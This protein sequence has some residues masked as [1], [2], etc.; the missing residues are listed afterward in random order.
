[1][2][3]SAPTQRDDVPDLQRAVSPATAALVSTLCFLYLAQCFWFITTQSLTYDEPVHIAQ[4]LDAWRNHRFEKWNDHPSLARLW[5]TLP[6]LGRKNVVEVEPLGEGWIATRLEPDPESLTRYGRLMNVL[7]GLMLAL[8][9]W[10]TTRTFFSSTAA[11]LV[12]ALFVFSPSLIAHFSLVTTD[13]AAT[14]LIF[15]AATLLMSWRAR[16]SYGRTCFMA[17]ILGLLLLAKFSTPVMFVIA[18]FWMLVL[19][20]AGARINPLLWNWRKTAVAIV[21]SMFV[22][23]A[24][25][26][27][28]VSRL[29]IHNHQLT[30]TFP[31]R[32]TVVFNNVRTNLELNILVPAGEYLDGFR[33]VV[34]RNRQGQ[35]S[36][37]MGQVSQTGGFRLYYPMAVLLKWPLIV[38]IVGGVGLG[39]CAYRRVRTSFDFWIMMSFPAVY[40]LVALVARFDIGERHILPV[41]AFFLLMAGA[42][43]QF[44]S[45]HRLATVGA[46]VI[47]GLLVADVSRYAPDYLS[48]FN[49]YVRPAQSYRLLTD[50]NLDW[51]Q[52]LIALRKY[53]RSHPG[54]PVSLAYFGSVDPRS[55]GLHV[56]VL[57]EAER[58][59]GTVIVSA[60]ALSGQYLKD[61][62]SFHWVQEYSPQ[63]LLNHS[64]FV[65]K[66]P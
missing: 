47:A 19:G 51:G 60:T 23:W 30:A 5:C 59:R 11:N 4:G 29:T 20:P 17:I 6:L 28:H 48:Y 57:G 41:Y 27:F 34:R 62:Q 36:Y 50:S 37:F 53:V 56:H 43:W 44:L 61:P 21:I 14:L 24:G 7:L 10:R 49:I 1:V 18:V 65:F 16:P 3:E 13:G 40:F 2:A 66:V 26:F 58:A 55:Y 31:H 39:L 22:V 35:R 46:L 25:C 32:P 63:S 54:E 45:K 8:L 33:N 52:G 42:T 38:L 12:L 64:L 9:V 15:A